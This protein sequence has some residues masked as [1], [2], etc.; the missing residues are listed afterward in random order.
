MYSSFHQQLSNLM[1]EPCMRLLHARLD[2]H[3]VGWRGWLASCL[4]TK[5]GYTTMHAIITWMAWPLWS[6]MGWC[7]ASCLMTKW[8]YTTMHAIVTWMG[9]SPWS[10]M[11][12]CL[13]SCLMTK[14]GYTTMHAIVTWMA[15]PPMKLDVGV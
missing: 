9:W 6:W 7:L 3:E 14:W 15:W 5:W 10:W 12:E 2:S 11:G 8:G 4:M 1:I 13:A